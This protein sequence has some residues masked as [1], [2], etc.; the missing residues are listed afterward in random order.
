MTRAF[1]LSSRIYEGLLAFYPA[2]LRRD[3]GEEMAYVFVEDLAAARREDGVRGCLRVWRWTVTEFVRIALPSWL[4]IPAVRVPAIALALFAG[5][6]LS[7][8]PW[9]LA[10]IPRGAP[11]FY[12]LRIVLTLPLF[13]APFICLASLWACR[14]GA[15]SMRSA[16]DTVEEQAPC[17]KLAI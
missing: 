7:V 11:N 17:S 13:A 16:T 8:L 15:A 12:K 6:M 2:D 5:M 10:E 3:Y 14:G 9:G 1:P 4:S